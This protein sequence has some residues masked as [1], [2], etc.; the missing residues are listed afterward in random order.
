MTPALPPPD[1]RRDGTRGIFFLH[2]GHPIARIVRVIGGG[3]VVERGL[4]AAVQR[5]VG[6]AGGLA[7]SVEDRRDIAVVVVRV[8]LG[9]EKQYIL[10]W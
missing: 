3:A 4:G 7:L 8:D 1:R 6:V 9:K 10:G 2:L 5:V